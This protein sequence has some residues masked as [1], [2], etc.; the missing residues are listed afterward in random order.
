M[1]REGCCA[2][3]S[4]GR[5]RV[6]H[7]HNWTEQEELY[8]DMNGTWKLS[9][10][11]EVSQK[12]KLVSYVSMESRKKWCYRSTY[13][14]SRDRHRLHRNNICTLSGEGEWG[15]IEGLVMTYIHYYGWSS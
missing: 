6:G 9:A 15:W 3:Y 4:W 14:P 2:K 10:Q 8:R 12:R 7:D 11:S 1:D 13:L 5:R